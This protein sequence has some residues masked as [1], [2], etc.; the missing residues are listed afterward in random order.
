MPFC[1]LAVTVSTLPSGISALIQWQNFLF[2]R[3]SQRSNLQRQNLA[4]ALRAVPGADIEQPPIDEVLSAVEPGSSPQQV[5]L[6]SQAA[7]SADISVVS[8]N[9]VA[10]ASVGSAAVSPTTSRGKVNEIDFCIAPADVSLSRA[11]GIST[12]ST[13][14][15]GTAS[16]ERSSIDPS[17]SLPILSL[18]RALNNASNRAVRRIL[19]AR[20]WPSAEALNLS[21]RRVAEAEKEREMARW[22]GLLASSSNTASATGGDGSTNSPKC[23][24]PRPILNVLM[25]KQQQQ[26][27]EGLATGSASSKN[28]PQPVPR[29]P[30]TD[31]EY[32][33]DQMK[34]FR[35]RYGSLPGYSL[36]EDYLESILRLAT[37][38][39]ESP[40]AE[41]VLQSRVY[42]ESYKRVL[43]VLKSGGVTLETD[44]TTGRNRIAAKL[45]DQDIC[46]SVMDKLRMKMGMSSKQMKTTVTSSEDMDS[47]GNNTANETMDSSTNGLNTSQSLKTEN[48]SPQYSRKEQEDDNLTAFVE[49]DKSVNKKLKLKFWEKDADLSK[50]IAE[51]DD[52]ITSEDLGGVLLSK[53]EP[54]MTRQ[55]NVLSN[56]VQRAL[57]FGGDEELLVLAET[58]DADRAAFIDRWYPNT[59]GPLTPKQSL[60]EE[61]RPGVQFFNC[62]V[63]LLQDCYEKGVVVEL[64]PP[65]PLSQSYANSYERLVALAVELGSGYIKPVPTNAMALPKPRTAQEELGRFAIWESKFRQSSKRSDVSAYPEDM[66]GK[67]E[68]RDEIGG[69]TIGI[70]TVVFNEQGEVKVDPPL[71]GLRWRLDPG[72]THLDTCTFQVLSSDGTILQYRGFIDRGARLEARFSKRAMKLRGSVMF[73]MRD[74]AVGYYK[75]ILPINYRTGTT[76]FVMTKIAYESS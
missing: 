13:A 61:T 27:S 54:S 51:E 32:V 57:L 21:L 2:Q 38:G 4:A 59:G 60:Q 33:A 55:L 43:A 76:K 11:Y 72:P 74:G 34:A 65:L 42:D 28:K 17:T 66:V 68:V 48:E 71:E 70:S 75:D 45:I 26:N 49:Q 36:A 23:P 29:S 3:L 25:R 52:S 44:A 9:P 41:A 18:T 64:E 8:S 5:S 37:A 12:T 39:V 50:P 24:V 22:A 31:E 73:Q 63:R 16:G 30:R 53:T 40:R 14:R 19:L 1:I 15:P 58:L 56:I 46:L 7:D 67:W 20:S 62:L 69:E 47:E 6:T 35:E 10:T